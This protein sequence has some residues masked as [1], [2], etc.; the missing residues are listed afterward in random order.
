TNLSIK[1]L[2][3]IEIDRT[4]RGLSDLENNLDFIAIMETGKQDMKRIIIDSILSK[5]IKDALFQME[6]N[7]AY[8]PSKCEGRNIL[9][10]VKM[11]GKAYDKRA[12]DHGQI[13]GVVKGSQ[14][15]AIAL[16]QNKF[17]QKIL[18]IVFGTVTRIKENIA[19]LDGPY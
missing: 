1:A 16:A 2:K 5:E 8:L 15:E 11:S 4:S 19:L 6:H 7:K 13:G 14:H 17:L 3:R 10:G 18:R 12:K 9:E